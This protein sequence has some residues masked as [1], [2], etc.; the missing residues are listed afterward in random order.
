MEKNQ[1]G[2]DGEKYCRKRE[3]RTS[4][5]QGKGTEEPIAVTL[6]GG[7]REITHHPAEREATG[8]VKEPRR[9]EKEGRGLPSMQRPGLEKLP[10]SDFGQQKQPPRGEKGGRRPA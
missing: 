1:T 5:N 3:G 6:E 10:C 2:E 8:F 9:G 7:T 4:G